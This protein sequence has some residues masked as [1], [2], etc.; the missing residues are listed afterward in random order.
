MLPPFRPRAC[1]PRTIAGAPRC[2]PT[3]GADGAI[4]FTLYTS[5]GRITTSG[6]ITA[7]PA[8]TANGN[9]NGI[10]A[11]PDGALWFTDS[12][13]NKIVRAPAC[14]LGLN[15]SFTDHT[16]TTNFDL[17]INRPAIWSF[18]VKNTVQLTKPIPAV[19]PPRAFTMHWEPFPN[20]GDVVVESALSTH[21]GAVLCSEWTTVKTAP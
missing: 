1:I 5:L 20:E 12:V 15:A 17:G 4:W 14:G 6:V 13:L 19:V 2:A 9:G 16:L 21:A 3:A 10:T 18:L 8:R 7:Y 11:G